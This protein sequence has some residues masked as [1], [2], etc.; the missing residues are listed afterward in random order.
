MDAGRETKGNSRQLLAIN[1]GVIL[2]IGPREI[3]F[4]ISRGESNR[5]NGNGGEIADH[6]QQFYCRGRLEMSTEDYTLREYL[7]PNQP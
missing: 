6:N 3:K 5:V 4:V 2:G 1:F 7:L